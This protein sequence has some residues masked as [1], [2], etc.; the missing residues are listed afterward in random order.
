MF[1]GL[2][3][4]ELGSPTPIVGDAADGALATL[5]GQYLVDGAIDSRVSGQA[6]D[7][8]RGE[9]RDLAQAQSLG[10]FAS[11][12]GQVLCWIDVQSR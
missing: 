11:T 10:N 8:I 9:D 7:G 6:V 1:P 2:A 5:D 3:D 4:Y 12:L